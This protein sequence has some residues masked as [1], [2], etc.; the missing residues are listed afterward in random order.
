MKKLAIISLSLIVFSITIMGQN[1][2]SSKKD[3]IVQKARG[4]QNDDVVSQI[5]DILAMFDRGQ[6]PDSRVLSKTYA[7][8]IVY[9]MSESADG[10]KGIYTLPAI[11]AAVFQCYDRKMGVL[12]MLPGEGVSSGKRPLTNYVQQYLRGNA[13]NDVYS[14]RYILEYLGMKVN[15][16]PYINNG[17]EFI[18]PDVN[19]IYVRQYGNDILAVTAN[20][21]FSEILI[22]RF[23]ISQ[24]MSTSA[25]LDDVNDCTITATFTQPK[26]KSRYPFQK[27]Y[28]VEDAPRTRGD[29]SASKSSSVDVDQMTDAAYKADLSCAVEAAINN[30]SVKT[31]TGLKNMYIVSSGLFGQNLGVKYNGENIH[32]QSVPSRGKSD[33]IQFLSTTFTG[34]RDR[35]CQFKFGIPC[36]N[37]YFTA[38]MRYDGNKWVVNEMLV[39]AE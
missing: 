14:S 5:N 20:D 21:D 37:V 23:K 24:A 6:I 12:R 1:Y 13:V 8:G 10:N 11:N 9:I 33:Y 7:H 30:K 38:T 4:Y 36:S 18:I 32:I 15:A 3:K 27:E 2:A 28:V 29:A 25:Q 19:N 17:D 35:D 26:Q 31:F 39:T 34:R 22:Y 16:L